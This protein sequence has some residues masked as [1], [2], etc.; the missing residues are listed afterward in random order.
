MA[1]RS[2]YDGPVHDGLKALD[3]ATTHVLF[4]DAG[5]KYQLD[6][7]GDLLRDAGPEAPIVYGVRDAQQFWHQRL[8]NRLFSIML[9]VRFGG[10]W[11]ADV[12][13]VRLIRRDTIAALQLEDRTFSLPFQT[14]VHALKQ[15][16]A[17]E[18][19]PIRCTT[20][21]IGMSKV[22]GSHRNSARAAVQMLLS[23]V[24]APDFGPGRRR[25][26]RSRR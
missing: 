5:G 15:G 11:V 14:T 7:I 16:I 9:K 20:G 25:T 4:L 10:P 3:E 26:G 21:R 23:L 24:K 22:S 2:G 12:S 1:Q 6:S 18:F 17:I 8:G 13:S 19:L